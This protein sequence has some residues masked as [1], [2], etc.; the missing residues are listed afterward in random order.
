MS[1]AVPEALSFS[2]LP[3]PLSSRCAMTT[4]SGGES[5]MPRFSVTR[6]TSVVRRPSIVDVKGSVCTR[7]PYGSSWRRNQAAAPLASGVPGLRSG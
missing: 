2:P 4:I 6:L 1:A 5:P 7:K 3:A